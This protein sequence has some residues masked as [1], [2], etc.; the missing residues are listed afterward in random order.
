M[1]TRLSGFRGTS[2]KGTRL[3]EARGYRRMFLAGVAVL[4]AA[5]VLLRRR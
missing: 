5:M 4:S 2:G 1:L 3:G